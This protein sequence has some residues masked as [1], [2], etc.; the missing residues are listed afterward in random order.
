VGVA[1]FGEFFF[2]F[3]NISAI[4]STGLWKAAGKPTVDL[5]LFLIDTEKIRQLTDMV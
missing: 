4:S 3:A 5:V 2:I 1:D